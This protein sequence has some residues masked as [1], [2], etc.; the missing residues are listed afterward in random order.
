[1]ARKIRARLPAILLLPVLVAACAYDPLP[2][3]RSREE[4]TPDAWDESAGAEASGA[5]TWSDFEDPLLQSL[6]SRALTDSPDAHSI[7]LRLA[8]SRLQLRETKAGSR[9]DYGIDGPSVSLNKSRYS[10]TRSNWSLNGRASYEVDI[11]GRVA[12]G[13]EIADLDFRVTEVDVRATRITLAAEITEA[14]FSLRGLDQQLALRRE[15]LEITLKQRDFTAARHEAGFIAG[16]ELDQ[17]EVEVQRQH[18]AIQDMTARRSRQQQRL[19][20]L[21]GVPPQNLLLDAD[22]GAFPRMPRMAPGTPA[23]VLR[24]RPDI[25]IAELRLA[26]AYLGFDRARKAIFPTLRLSGNSGF[27]STSLSKLLTS[28]AFNWSVGADLVTTL[29]DNG[30]RSR[31]VERVRLQAEQQIVD[32]RRTILRAL[33]EVEGALVSQQ[34]N[35]RQI[36]IQRLS[37]AAQERVA[38]ETAARYRA[39]SASARDLI[40]E[41][42]SLLSQREQEIQNWLSGMRATVQLLRAVGVQPD[43]DGEVAPKP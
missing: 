23:D 2:L 25:Q 26:G 17:Q 21:M 41:Q 35:I 42:R 24:N 6:I 36:E 40:R 22:D 7:I 19:A 20:V 16:I 15:T 31:G 12:D 11:W 8:S 13:V 10:D 33:E 37:V 43:Q 1:M 28:A 9:L 34:N 14:Y 4:L 27:A 32:Y 30:A 38:R 3:D 18:S 39:G 5:L 29:L